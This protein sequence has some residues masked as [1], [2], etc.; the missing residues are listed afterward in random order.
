MLTLT[1]LSNIKLL[2]R[3]DPVSWGLNSILER[4]QTAVDAH[5]KAG[6]TEEPQPPGVFH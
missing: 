3:G 6:K 5:G 2:I 4:E 1:Y